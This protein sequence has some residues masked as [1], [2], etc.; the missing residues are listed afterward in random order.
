[1]GVDYFCCDICGEI[2]ADCSPCRCKR[3]P[4]RHDRWRFCYDCRQDGKCPDCLPLKERVELFE[5]IINDH[6]SK[7][8]GWKKLIERHLKDQI[9]EET[10]NSES[11]SE[12]DGNNDSD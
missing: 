6:Q 10:R 8:N 2:Q 7:I 4:N 11:D 5:S 3:F 9:P 1:M 12:S